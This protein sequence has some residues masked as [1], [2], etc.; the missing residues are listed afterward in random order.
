M[1]I[2]RDNALQLGNRLPQI[3][4]VQEFVYLGSLITNRGDIEEEIRRRIAI[5]RTA[6]TNLNDLDRLANHSEQ[7]GLGP[8]S[9]F[10]YLLY[11]V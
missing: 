5:A 1:I 7:D 4:K 11:E 9:G 3:E 6:M 10:L 2:D 8:Y